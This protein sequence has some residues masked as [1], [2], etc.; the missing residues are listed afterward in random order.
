[1]AAQPRV[2][3]SVLPR[4]LRMAVLYVSSWLI[5]SELKFATQNLADF[6]GQSQGLLESTPTRPACHLPAT[7][8]RGSITA[9]GADPSLLLRRRSGHQQWTAAIGV[10]HTPAAA[11]A[12]DCF[13]HLE[14]PG[15]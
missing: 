12:R 10:K 4:G 15:A 2:V 5:P 13:C 8:H 14:V 3:P 1:A 9:D 11:T 6:V 7:A